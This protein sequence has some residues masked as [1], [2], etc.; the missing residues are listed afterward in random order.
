MVLKT[1]RF[2]STAVASVEDPS[3]VKGRRISERVRHREG[4]KEPNSFFS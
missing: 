4:N 2:K 1:E 3:M